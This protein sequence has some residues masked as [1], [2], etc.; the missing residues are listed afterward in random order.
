MTVD[1]VTEI[2]VTVTAK[3]NQLSY[4]GLKTATNVNI[5]TEAAEVLRIRSSSKWQNHNSTV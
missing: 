5:N 2:Y 1:N 4:V 3:Q